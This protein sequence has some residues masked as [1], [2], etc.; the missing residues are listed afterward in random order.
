MRRAN[1]SKGIGKTHDGIA[2]LVK[3]M[4]IP[5]INSMLAKVTIMGWAEACR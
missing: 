1:I 4:P 5:E 2:T 3:A